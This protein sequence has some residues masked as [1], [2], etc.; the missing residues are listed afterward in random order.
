MG[1]NSLTENEE[2]VKILNC[3]EKQSKVSQDQSDLV[4]HGAAVLFVCADLAEQRL[5][6]YYQLFKSIE[7]VFF[8]SDTLTFFIWT[9]FCCWDQT[10]QQL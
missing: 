1:A 8:Y 10:E 4:P 6:I 5:N 7:G 3:T 9:R 2:L